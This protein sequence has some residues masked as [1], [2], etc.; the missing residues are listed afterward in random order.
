MNVLL[1]IKPCYAK[2]ILEGSK[3]YE[4]R[5]RVF[6]DP[7]V[8]CVFMYSTAPEQKVV[9]LFQVREIVAASP[10]DLWN[11]V[12]HDSGVNEEVFFSYFH[13]AKTGYAIGVT[14]PIR[15]DC[16]I[17]PRALHAGFRPPQSF[18]YVTSTTRL[19]KTLA[20]IAQGA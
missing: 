5:R 6:R 7:R 15:F 11:V 8:D 20:T 9:G 17:D 18:A 2:A 12:Q 3:R 14:T 4:L 10:Q 16:P 1:S 19:G 13:L